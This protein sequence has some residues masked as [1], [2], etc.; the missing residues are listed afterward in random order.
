MSATAPEVIKSQHDVKNTSLFFR[1]WLAN[2]LQMGSIIPSSPALCRRVAAAVERG[3]EDYVLEIGAGTGV[4]S[5]ALIEAG[6]PA[7]KLIVVEIVTEMAEH[8]REALPGANVICGDAFDLGRIMPAEMKNRIGTAI[9]GIP[10][11]M[12]PRDRQQAFIDAV[13][14]VA[15][16]KGFLLYT[17]CV[18]SPLSPGKLKLDAKRMAWTPLNFPPASVWRYRPKAHQA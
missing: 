5:K 8:L 17:Y 18:T 11:V 6:V 13:E 2:P 10:L 15:P 7:R 14:A 16:G 1:R 9:C 4:I 12:L 3:T